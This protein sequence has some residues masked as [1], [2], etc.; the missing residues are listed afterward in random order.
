MADLEVQGHGLGMKLVLPQ[1][2]SLANQSFF[3]SDATLQV[4]D[5]VSS[6]GFKIT[7]V[8]SGTFGDV[9]RVEKT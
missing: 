5:S 4:G 1:N 6:N 3:L 7:V 8:E 9:V 2:L